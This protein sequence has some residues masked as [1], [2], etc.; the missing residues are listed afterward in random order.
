MNCS[1]LDFNYTVSGDKVNCET[2]ILAIRSSLQNG[3][4]LA[5]IDVD[6][7]LRDTTKRR[8]LLP[9]ERSVF[10]A[11]DDMKN[12]MYDDFNNK[13]YTD[14]LIMK[15]FELL[16]S[17]EDCNYK[18]VLL[19]SCTYNEENRR[20]L[21][22]QASAGGLDVSNLIV[23]MRGRENHM[24]AVGLKE[25]FLE[26]TN[27]EEFSDNILAIDDNAKSCEMFYKKGIHTLRFLK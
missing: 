22:S 14:T 20:V 12:R 19:T 24:D 8:G 13:C 23:V 6:D 26:T 18:I 25:Y 4:K 27:L 16:Q 17:L 2:G 10:M 7:T 1:N 5:L 21:I 9:N 15:N 11:P 3:M